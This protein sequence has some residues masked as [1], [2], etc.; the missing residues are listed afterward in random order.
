MECTY[1][2]TPRSKYEGIHLKTETGIKSE[3]ACALL[4]WQLRQTDPQRR[5]CSVANYVESQQKCELMK[6]NGNADVPQETTVNLWNIECKKSNLLH[7]CTKKYR[8]HERIVSATPA[9]AHPPSPFPGTCGQTTVTQR[10][11]AGFQR[12]VGGVEAKQHSLPFLVSLRTYTGFHFCGGSLIRV[13]NKDES[14]IVVTAAHC[15]NR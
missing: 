6:Y 1:Y 15:V 2:A 9:P 4:C 11:K 7:F 14:D 12:I 8:K 5:W 13:G 10:R 3:E